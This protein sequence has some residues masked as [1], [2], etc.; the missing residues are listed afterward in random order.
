MTR[1]DLFKVNA[2]IVKDIADAIAR[3]APKAWIGIITNPVNSTVPIAAEILK[4]HKIYNPKTL[5]G[6]STLDV[7]RAQA[8][9]GELKN[10]DSSK[11]KIDVIGGHSPDTMIPVFSQVQGLKFSEEEI[12]KLTTDIKEAGTYVVNAKQ[13]TGS[14]TLSMAYAGARFALNLV[15]AMHGEKGVVECSYVD[16]QGNKAEAPTQFFALPIEFGVEG[17]LKVHPVPK[18]NDFESAQLKLA[19]EAI[20]KNIETGVKF[21]S[22]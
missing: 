19:V 1:D 6:V 16:V 10:V 3:N 18:L 22:S 12:K 2:G 5:F 17:V 11:V 14:A 13:G 9:I 7:V 15:R 21:A 8:F 20:K 4:K